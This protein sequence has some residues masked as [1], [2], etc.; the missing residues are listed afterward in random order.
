[1][2][3]AQSV[4]KEL[5]WERHLLSEL[6]FTQTK[7]TLL[8]TDNDGVLKQSTKSINHSTAKHYRIAQ[9]YIRSMAENKT[10]TVERVDTA[11]NPADFFTKAL[12]F[13][14]FKRHRATIM[15][16]QSPAHS[17]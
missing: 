17:I 10:V 6:G 5:V 7:P 8:Q 15:G 4:V 14:V 13:P 11:Q 12:H 3:A 9:A 16:P 2:Y 1:M